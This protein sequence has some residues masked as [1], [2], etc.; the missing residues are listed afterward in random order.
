MLF[1]I[2]S[3]FCNWCLWY[4]SKCFNYYVTAFYYWMRLLNK[5]EAEEE[6]EKQLQEN[7]NTINEG[8]YSFYMKIYKKNMI[9]AK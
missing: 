6:T 3:L 8:L 7:M 4:K 9:I 1:E 2:L 5:L